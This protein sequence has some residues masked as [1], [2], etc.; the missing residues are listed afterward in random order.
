MNLARR[1]G[2]ENDRLI[3]GAPPRPARDGPT[4]AGAEFHRH[5]L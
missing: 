3:C 1:E 5:G 2:S 4:L